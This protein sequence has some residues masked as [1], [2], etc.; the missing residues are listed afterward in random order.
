M[1][2]FVVL[3]LIWLVL[4]VG[5][6]YYSG[7]ALFMQEEFNIISADY[8]FMAI[9]CAV[10]AAPMFA[11]FWRLTA[12]KNG[13]DRSWMMFFALLIMGVMLSPVMLLIS[14]FINVKKMFDLIGKIKADVRIVQAVKKADKGAKRRTPEM[15][16]DE[17]VLSKVS[18][19]KRRYLTTATVALEKILDDDNDEDVFIDD[20]KVSMK[21]RQK[22]VM[23]SKDGGLYA[24]LNPILPNVDKNTVIVYEIGDDDETGWSTLI[25]V[26]DEEEYARLVEEYTEQASANR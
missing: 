15:S 10:L 9:G 12:H 24:F 20:G 13:A 26:T 17:E 4:S 25:P 11:K 1:V 23:K 5:W 21:L 18:P 7:Q 14:M 19:S 8:F 2:F 16:A 6:V 3:R 22:G